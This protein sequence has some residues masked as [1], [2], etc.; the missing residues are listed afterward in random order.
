MCAYILTF[1]TKTSEERAEICSLSEFPSGSHVLFCKEINL[2]LLDE[3][4]IS[5]KHS[6]LKHK[7]CIIPTKFKAETRSGSRPFRVP[8]GHDIAVLKKKKNAIYLCV[9]MIFVA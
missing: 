2:D 1:T 8:I 7:N 5:R 4:V 6:W 3:M 9:S